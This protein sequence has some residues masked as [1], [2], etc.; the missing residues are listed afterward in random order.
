MTTIWWCCLSLISSRTLTVFVFNKIMEGNG[1]GSTLFTAVELLKTWLVIQKPQGKRCVVVY[2]LESIQQITTY[3]SESFVF[4]AACKSATT[5]H[6]PY[7]V[8]SVCYW[9]EHLIPEQFVCTDVVSTP[10][11]KR[12]QLFSEKP[13]FVNNLLS[14]LLSQ[15][16]ELLTVDVT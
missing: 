13:K 9:N 12:C 15:F 2:V 8:Q 4:M 10:C 16:T 1:A 11:V 6:A 14:R 3:C 5:K 7:L